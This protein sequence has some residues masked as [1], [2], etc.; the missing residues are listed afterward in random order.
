MEIKIIKGG[1]DSPERYKYITGCVTNTRLMGVLAMHLEWEDTILPDSPHFHQYFYFDCEEL[2]LETVKFLQSDDEKLTTEEQV[3]CFAGLG[4]E[5]QVLSERE[6]RYLVCSMV[7]R[8]K[9][10]GKLLP[11]EVRELSYITDFP[12]ELSGGEYNHLQSKLNAPIKSDYGV[13]NYYLM[14]MFGKDAVAAEP[15]VSELARKEDIEDITPELHATFLRNRI[16]TIE[17]GGQRRE[18]KCETLIEVEKEAKHY[19]IVSTIEVYKR[20]VIALSK[21]SSM[22]ISAFEASMILNKREYVTVYRSPVI[23]D[24]FANNFVAR[25]PG[26]THTEHP[27]GTMYMD[28]MSDNSHAENK[29]FYLN[30]DVNALYYI[31]DAGELVVTAYSF[32]KIMAAEAKL[33]NDYGYSLY[34][35][36]RYQFQT[37]LIYDFI[38]SGAEYFQDYLDALGL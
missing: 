19:L 35:V 27:A 4:A 25:N 28:Y 2:G 12:P 23:F 20:K 37:S 29:V 15:L 33:A 31:G 11:K 6:A 38:E 32:E 5:P 22:A 1:L 16:E 24:L 13:I 9:T 14:R 30:D 36:G 34:V 26:M 10:F 8:T 3:R 18:Y 17:T 7:L 21:I